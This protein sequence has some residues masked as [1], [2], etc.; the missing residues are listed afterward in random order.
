MTPTNK[1]PSKPG[2]VVIQHAFGSDV[3]IVLRT[4]LSSFEHVRLFRSYGNGYN[5][6]AADH[7]LE[8]EPATVDAL[9]ETETVRSALADIGMIDP[10]T[11]SVSLASAIGREEVERSV[12]MQGPIATDD[13]PE[14][15]FAW[16][17]N[18]ALLLFS[19]E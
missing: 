8:F 18:T 5:V 19:N 16:S 2:G 10:I 11:P 14:L 1:S 6:V 15:E 12:P 9:L 13:R 17:G 3:D 4:L 7:P